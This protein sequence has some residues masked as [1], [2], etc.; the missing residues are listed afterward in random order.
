MLHAQTQSEQF[1]KF[2]KLYDAALDISIDSTRTLVTSYLNSFPTD[3]E[4]KTVEKFLADAYF[5]SGNQKK[6]DSIY[7]LVIP[8][9]K[10]NKVHIPL[11]SSYKSKGV[12]LYQ[13][14]AISEILALTEEALQY[15]EEN[16]EFLQT[17][18]LQG[19]ISDIYRNIAIAY[20]IQ[21]E[22]D[23]GASLETSETYFRKA[24]NTLLPFDAPIK[25]GLALFNLGN[26]KVKEDSIV[27]Y[28]Q[29]ALDIFERHNA[30]PQKLMVYGNF[31]GYYIDQKE[32]YSKGIEYL[33]KIDK[34]QSNNPNKYLISIHHVK[35][36]GAYIGLGNYDK[37]I[38]KLKIGLS[39]AK[40]NDLLDLQREASSRLIEAYQLAGRYKEALE[41]N[42]FYDSIVKEMDRL[43]TERIFR[44]TEAK[45]K[46]KEQ[47]AEIEFLKQEEL[48]KDTQ[49]RQQRLFIGL[50]AIALILIITLTY[51]FW[52]RAQQR[53]KMNAQLVKLNKDRT[54]FLVNISHELRTP[55]SL[56]HGPLQ[57]T[58]EQLEKNNLNRVQRNLHKIANNTQKL[59][60]LTDEVLDIS[61]LDEGFLQVHLNPI[62]LKAFVN[63]AFYA[64]ESL[65][66]RNKIKW[67]SAISIPENVYEVDEN[68]LEKIL[69]NLFSNAIN[70]TPK[71]GEVFFSATVESN[72][73]V[74][75]IKDTGK[76]ISAEA[77]PK[78]F[79]RYFQ[80]DSQEKPTGGIG[81]GLSLVKELIDILKGTIQ[82]QSEL[83]V[84]TEFLL[85]I[86]VKV[87]DKE[88]V[89]V[90]SPLPILDTENRPDIDLSDA[91]KPHVLVIEDH[92]EMADF[93]QQ[94]LSDDYRVS[95]ASNGREGIKRLQSEQ[96]DMITVD[97]MMPE[98]DGIEFVTQLKEHPD[99]KSISTIMITAL[100]E[101]SD[102][103]TGL[104]LG[105]DDYITKPLKGLVM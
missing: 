93:I 71:N 87:S 16:A 72:Q 12:I 86:P 73:L 47:Q 20:A 91:N 60:Q 41:T 81:I 56:I 22:R 80:D 75:R 58:L 24:Y 21:S 35:F 15:A 78:I 51:L 4:N 39:I 59:L 26:I 46:T 95:L 89:N 28:W 76:G 10:N 99:W 23:G 17:K 25:K 90:L 37:A 79:N 31:A 1:Q 62:D 69:N 36:G 57:D 63:R 50:I 102:K 96:F 9:F 13:T 40:E 52:K 67:T 48:L 6:A 2:K 38:Q 65:A 44:D 7:T 77:I 68:K 54:R 5:D 66:I 105:V 103:I 74:C 85:T 88:A 19:Y 82:V 94:L 3:L 84:G 34:Q 92:I 100:S 32:D 30:E 55:V 97:V 29:S 70:H 101:E 11:L 64:F 8:W 45:Y 104:Q 14:G 33:K 98:M 83:S 49:I 61:K 18:R 27:F 53:K 42:R 43:E